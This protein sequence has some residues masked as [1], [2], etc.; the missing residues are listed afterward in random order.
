M[1]QGDRIDGK[2]L[3]SGDRGLPSMDGGKRI[4]KKHP[5]RICTGVEVV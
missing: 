2:D 1:A 4:C 5:E 3:G